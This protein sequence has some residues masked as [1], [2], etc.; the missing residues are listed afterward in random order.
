MWNPKVRFWKA[1]LL[2]PLHKAK[3][4]GGWTP[5]PPA[6]LSIILTS[7][8]EAPLLSL[9]RTGLAHDISL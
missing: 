8:R 2:W 7:T 6:L 3:G 1:A 4:V 5:S 9:I